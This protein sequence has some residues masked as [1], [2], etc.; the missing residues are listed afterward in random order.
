MEIQ[1]T[2]PAAIT[3]PFNTSALVARLKAKV[4][5]SLKEP[6]KAAANET[7]DWAAEGCLAHP[8]GFVKGL[9]GLMVALKEPVSKMI[10]EKL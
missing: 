8:N 9:S 6:I 3:S 7:L 1:A 4:M 10:D 5:I 2:D